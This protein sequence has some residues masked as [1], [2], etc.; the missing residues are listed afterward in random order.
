MVSILLNSYGMVIK[1]HLGAIDIAGLISHHDC[2]YIW[3]NHYGVDKSH[4]TM[5]ELDY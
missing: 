3:N 5:L 1:K 4:L 2:N